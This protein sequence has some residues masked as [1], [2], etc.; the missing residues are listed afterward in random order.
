[1]Q[2]AG[3]PSTHAYGMRAFEIMCQTR[4]SPHVHA[5]KRWLWAM[6]HCGHVFLDALRTGTKVVLHPPETTLQ[7]DHEQ[8]KVPERN[9]FFFMSPWPHKAKIVL[10]GLRQ[11]RHAS[12]FMSSLGLRPGGFQCLS[13]TCCFFS[14]LKKRRTLSHV[15]KRHG[16][17]F[18]CT[19]GARDHTPR[20]M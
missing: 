13:K 8:H 6:A 3:T 11:K 14:C 16:V 20:L 9:E 19:F 4:I 17:F 2:S 12:Y 1:M 15:S 7:L 5:S 18:M 10:L